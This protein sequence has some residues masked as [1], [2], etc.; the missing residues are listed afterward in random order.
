MAAA[1]PR[2]LRILVGLDEPSG[3]TV[4]RAKAIR[5]GYLPQ[6]AEFEMDGTVWEACVSVLRT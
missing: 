5:L 1:R 2:Y 6:E 4:S 3:G